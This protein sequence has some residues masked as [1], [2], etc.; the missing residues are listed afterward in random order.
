M[1]LRDGQKKMSKSD[2]SPMTR[3]EM[4][5]DNDTISKK[6]MK[7]TSD[8]MLLPEKVDELEERPEAKNLLNIYSAFSGETIEKVVAR[9]QGSQFYNFKKELAEVVV[10]NMGPVRDEFLRLIADKSYIVKVVNE[11]RERA[12]QK[13]APVISEAKVIMGLG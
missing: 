5:D 3:I 10:E 11:G 13:S 2:P 12:V 9:F 7:A 1:S 6:V 4:V 8:P